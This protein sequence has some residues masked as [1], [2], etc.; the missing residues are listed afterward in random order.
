MKNVPIE[1]ETIG[2]S[3]L[4]T[5]TGVR[6]SMKK[7]SMG[8]FLLAMVPGYLFA[9]PVDLNSEAG[10]INYSI[11]YQVGSDFKK[12]GWTF[13]AERFVQGVRAAL[14]NTTPALSP[15]EMNK[16][17]TDVKKRVLASETRSARES[18][19]SF[20]AQHARED[21]V[22]VLPSGVQYKVLRTGEGK[23]PTL[24]DSVTIQ[25]KVSKA[26]GPEIATAY[27]ESKPRTYALNKALPGLQETMLMM[28]EGSRWEIVLPPG[29][30]LG[31]RG[32]A[33]E[34]AGILVYDLE[35]ISVQSGN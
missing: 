24:K 30:A 15:A 14:E 11:G 28:K 25:Y 17:L 7:W 10:R 26:G 32:E 18:D 31:N 2:L 4:F 22:V 8:F 5:R 19:T 20:L 35:L 6:D 34:P 21:G 9:A 12:E 3:S 23:M 33:L 13:D 16:T 1:L 29:P 27:P